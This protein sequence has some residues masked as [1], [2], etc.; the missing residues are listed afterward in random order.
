MRA[1]PFELPWSTSED[2]FKAFQKM[3][4][5]RPCDYSVMSY[6]LLTGGSGIQ[7]P[8]TKGAP[9]GTER[10]FTDGKFFTDIEYCESYGHDL[11]TGAPYTK[12]RYMNFNPAGKA[13]LKAAHYS[14][15]L[16]VP[17]EE[18]PYQLSTGRNVFHFHTRSK[19]GR[20]KPLQDASPDARVALSRKGASD[21]GVNDGDMVLL[22]SRRGKIEVPAAIGEI[23]ERQLFI[24]FH[25]GYWDS[26]DGRARAANE[27][28][29]EQWDP[30]SK[31]PMFKSGAVR[32]E[33]VE[34]TG[35][36][37]QIKE[38]QSESVKN[39]AEAKPNAQ[40]IEDT[41][42]R[43]RFVHDWM[44]TTHYS[45]DVLIDICDKL[46][47]GLTYDLEIVRG[48]KIMRRIAGRISERM[49]PFDKRAERESTG[50]HAG[51]SYIRGSSGWPGGRLG[52]CG[53]GF[54][55]QEFVDTVG[56]VEAELDRMQAWVKQ[57][58]GVRAPQVLTVPA[59]FEG[60]PNM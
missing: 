52:S 1:S 23:A 28:T 32:I 37:V 9:Q 33:K 6:E 44:E 27:L 49:K 46:I 45:V 5:G 2:A 30:I 8:C 55:D 19:T 18:Y 53:T 38:L 58:I 36:Q 29:D 31:Q 54:W 60:A 59:P 15:G 26:K 51:L 39:A 34:S 14:P 7:W 42:R 21:L 50:G 48:M 13:F 3:S 17:D 40:D 12:D 4:A 11:E 16:E 43:K 25:Y 24:P 57:Q 47:P 10:L 41:S 22:E 20:S 56:F 35:P